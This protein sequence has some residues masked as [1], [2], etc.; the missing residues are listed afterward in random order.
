MK[1]HTDK[2]QNKGILMIAASGNQGKSFLEYPASSQFVIGV[3]AVDS[4][5]KKWVYSNYGDELDFVLPGVFY[6]S[7]KAL[8]KVLRMRLEL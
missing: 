3:G 1:V 7:G 6:E 2:S 5:G 4:N 8:N